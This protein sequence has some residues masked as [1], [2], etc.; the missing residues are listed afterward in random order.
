MG[1]N[2]ALHHSNEASDTTQNE[3]G[4]YADQSGM[5]GFSYSQDDGPVMCFNAPKSWQLGWYQSR[6]HVFNQVDGTWNGRLIGQVDLGNS[7]TQS[8][9]K[10]I[11]KLNVASDTDHCVIFNRKSG[12]N[13]GTLDGGDKV[14]IQ[15]AGAEGN[16][17]AQ[18]ELH[19][20]LSAGGSYTIPNYDSSGI[21][22]VLTVNSIDFAANP[23]YADISI[24]AGCSTD[25]E[26]DDEFACNGVETCNTS[27]AQCISGEPE[28]G[29]CG[30]GMCESGFGESF[31]SLL[32]LEDCADGPFKIKSPLCSSCFG[33]NGHMFGTYPTQ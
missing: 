16:Y 9:D 30:N 10:V 5:M 25:P 31:E 26:C 28:A 32:C 11:L 27:T 21:D 33:Q 3:A 4:S 22:L 20:K 8:S 18:S 23:P 2:L 19:A 7:N 24:F 29:C 1:H 15:S 17:A 14:M 13:S 6:H 12:H